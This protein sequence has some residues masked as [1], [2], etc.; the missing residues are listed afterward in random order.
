M[1]LECPDYAVL[2]VYSAVATPAL[3]G[4]QVCPNSN[5]QS[6]SEGCENM[7]KLQVT[8]STLALCGV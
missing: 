1:R 4:S 6:G 8:M 3:F 5:N 2:H 7:S